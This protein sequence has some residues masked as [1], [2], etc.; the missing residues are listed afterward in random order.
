[1]L[2]IEQGKDRIMGDGLVLSRIEF[3]GDPSA[4]HRS[5]AGPSSRQHYMADSRLT[6]GHPR[7]G[8]E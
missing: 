2:C 8:K 7:V 5:I 3:Q 6:A 1:M 4:L